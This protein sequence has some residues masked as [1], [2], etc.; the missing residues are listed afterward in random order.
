MSDLILSVLGLIATPIIIYAVVMLLLRRFS[1][2]NK[3]EG[4]HKWQRDWWY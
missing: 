4:D 1:K 3:V 2:V